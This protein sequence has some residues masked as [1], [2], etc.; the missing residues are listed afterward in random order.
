MGYRLDTDRECIDVDECVIHGSVNLCPSSSVCLNTPGSFRCPCKP[1]FRYNITN[2]DVCEDMDECR[3]SDHGC[4]HICFNSMGSYECRCRTG[5]ALKD[6]GKSCIDMDECKIAEENQLTTKK[7]IVR[8]CQGTCENTIGSYRC[9]CPSGYTLSPENQRSCQDVNECDKHPCS[10]SH[11][12]LNTRGGYKCYNTT[13]APGY[14][15]DPA[16]EK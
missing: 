7:D 13:C 14:Q 12:C 1:G 5:F 16:A 2:P 8:L 9:S 10:P 11:L 4:Q 15:A 6:D 3:S